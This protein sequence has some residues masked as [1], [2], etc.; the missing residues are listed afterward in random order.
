MHLDS[1]EIFIVKN[2][3]LLSQ[4]KKIYWWLNQS[5]IINI[6]STREVRSLNTTQESPSKN[7]L[8]LAK[9]KKEFYSLINT[10][11]IIISTMEGIMDAK[12][13]NGF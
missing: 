8:G 11:K 1:P 10:K 9:I 12:R 7:V 4:Y 5:E 6:Q 2:F 3:E 13:E